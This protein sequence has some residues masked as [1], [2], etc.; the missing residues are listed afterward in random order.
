MLVYQREDLGVPSAFLRAKLPAGW[1]KLGEG[2]ALFHC[3]G[4]YVVIFSI[5]S[6]RIRNDMDFWP[7]N[8]ALLR[9][10]SIRLLR[11]CVYEEGFTSP[12]RRLFCEFSFSHKTPLLSQISRIAFL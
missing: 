12:T 5:K 11:F 7:N 4:S 8:G 2:L 6:D 3:G 10:T 1:L 9:R